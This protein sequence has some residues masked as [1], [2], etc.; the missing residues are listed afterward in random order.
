M[1]D[2][3]AKP[4]AEVEA[5]QEDW[6]MVSALMGGTKAM[7]AAGEKYL[8]KWPAEDQDSYDFRLKTS[9]L[10]NFYGH[11][12]KT[13]GSKPFAK[14]VGMVDM[15]EAMIPWLEN[16]DTEGRNLHV[17]AHDVFQ[18]AL[19][20][21]LSHMLVDYPRVEGVR[22]LA[23]ERKAGARPYVVHIHP[24]SGLGWKSKKV[25]GRE[26]LTQLR[27]MESVTEDDGEFGSKSVAQVRVLEPGAWRIYRKVTEGKNAGSWTLYD[28]GTTTIDFIPLVTVYT[29]RT[30]FMMAKPPL[31]DIADLNI[32]HWQSQS[33]QD[34]IL[35]VAR[36]PLLA[37]SGVD[38]V[39]EVRV[40]AKAFMRLPTGAVAQWVEHS[41]AAISAGREPL[42]DLEEQ[43]RV[44]GA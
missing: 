21:G 41:G 22:T 20:H 38:G 44:L 5:M 16:I 31:L 13:M 4:S 28:E 7:R 3:V 11:T 39:S 32:K 6:A 34:S 37:V 33:D 12:V 10:T 8:P 36:V 19:G 17:F 24:T 1:S 40:V 42:H 43:M 35:H 14:A 25:E 29:N 15:P 18:A 30:G 9:T 23:D 27:F 2:D 26:M